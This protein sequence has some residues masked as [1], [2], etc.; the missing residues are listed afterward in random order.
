[1][2][3]QQS[4]VATNIPIELRSGVTQAGSWMSGLW[5]LKNNGSVVIY[6]NDWGFPPRKITLPYFFTTNIAKLYCFPSTQSLFVGVSTNGQMGLM[7]GTNSNSLILPAAAADVVEIYQAGPPASL[8][9][10]THH[11]GGALKAW[12]LVGGTNVYLT[13]H[14]CSG[15][16]D[17]R[18]VAGGFDKGVAITGNGQL[19][20][21]NNST[22][23]SVIPEITSTNVVLASVDSTPTSLTYCLLGDGTLLGW[24]NDGSVV[25]F[26]AE[27]A[28]ERFVNVL[29]IGDRGFGLSRSGYLMSWFFMD[30]NLQNIP[31]PPALSSGLIQIKDF[32]DGM[33]NGFFVALNNNGG[34]FPFRNLGGPSGWGV[35]PAT[36]LPILQ[37]GGELG[38]FSV[39]SSAGIPQQNISLSTNADL[40]VE[41]YA[42]LPLDVLAKLVAEKILNISNNFGLATKTEVGGAVTQGV[43]QVLSAPSEYN[44]F[45]TLQVQAERTAGQN[46]VVANP[47]QW[48][49][50]T[51]N[52]IS[53]MAI[54]DLVLTRTNNGQFVLNYDIEQSEDLVN[55]Y[56][57]QGFAM[58]LTNLPT[59]KAFVRIKAKQ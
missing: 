58:P 36:P 20:G 3:R 17:V 18:K 1:M 41:T 59:N 19:H 38:S 2:G 4:L 39:V 31:L 26:P 6:Q 35:D 33:G 49:L 45:T 40:A 13:D 51:T 24:Q 9:F 12:E 15:L 55:W 11:A 28:N 21:W 27:V 10:I 37:N 7:I 52:Q 56:P 16:S 30:G 42:G 8:K 22:A 5:A 47:N 53:A 57:Y 46:D 54:G 14:V 23:F 48:T 50:Y 44:L 25:T 34:L 29:S 32:R 43:Q